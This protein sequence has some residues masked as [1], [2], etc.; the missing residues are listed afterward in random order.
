MPRAPTPR[1]QRSSAL[2]RLVLAQA[3]RLKKRQE[4]QKASFVRVISPP[5]A[6]RA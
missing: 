5:C 2:E 4:A 1:L 3:K 6:V